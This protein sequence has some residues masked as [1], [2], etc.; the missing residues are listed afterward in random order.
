MPFVFV[1]RSAAFFVPILLVLARPFP[2]HLPIWQEL[3]LVEPT[4][5]PTDSAPLPRSWEAGQR[6]VRAKMCSCLSA[7]TPCS[8][9]CAVPHFLL[10]LLHGFLGWMTGPFAGGKPM[11]H[12]WWIC[13]DTAL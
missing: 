9:C 5:K 8:G 10:P 12:C 3:T 2:S 4:D 1:S 7:G 6:L 11:P 13:N